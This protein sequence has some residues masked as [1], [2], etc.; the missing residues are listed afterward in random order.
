MKNSQET[1]T[2]K[3]YKFRKENVEFSKLFLEAI[4]LEK[5]G[6]SKL[7]LNNI[8]IKLKSLITLQS[9]VASDFLINEDEKDE[10]YSPIAYAI[11]QGCND[12]IKFLFS[13]GNLIRNTTEFKKL[14]KFYQFIISKVE[15]DSLKDFIE[16]KKITNS[17]DNS[18]PNFYDDSFPNYKDIL[19]NTFKLYKRISIDEKFSNIL[20]FT[21]SKLKLVDI[22]LLNI[23]QTRNGTEIQKIF[24]DKIK[25]YGCK[26]DLDS[27]LTRGGLRDKDHLLA[28]KTGLDLIKYLT[29][30]DLIEYKFK[31]TN[32]LNELV[33]IYVD[34]KIGKY[35]FYAKFDPKAFMNNALDY[36]QHLSSKNINLSLGNTFFLYLLELDI[37]YDSAILALQNESHLIKSISSSNT[38]LL[39]AVLNKYNLVKRNNDTKKAEF[40]KKIANFILDHIEDIGLEH[41]D[42][43]GRN[44]LHLAAN[45]NDMELYQKIKAL[46]PDLANIPDNRKYTPISY[47]G[48]MAIVKKIITKDNDIEKPSISD[49]IKELSRLLNIPYTLRTPA[50]HEQ[51]KG[52]IEKIKAILDDEEFDYT[53]ID[54]NEH[55]IIHNN[56]FY[57][58]LTFN[59]LQANRILINAINQCKNNDPEVSDKLFGLKLELGR[60]SELLFTYEQSGNALTNTQK[61]YKL[62]IN[63]LF[64]N[65]SKKYISSNNS[66]I[67]FKESYIESIKG[68]F[69]N[70]FK[71]ELKNFE[72]ILGK[73]LLNTGERFNEFLNYQKTL[74]EPN[75]SYDDKHNFLKDYLALIGVTHSQRPLNASESIDSEDASDTTDSEDASEIIDSKILFEE[76]YFSCLPTDISNHILDLTLKSNNP[77]SD[78]NPNITGTILLPETKLMNDF[79]NLNNITTTIHT[80]SSRALVFKPELLNFLDLFNSDIIKQHLKDIGI[81]EEDQPI[82]VKSEINDKNKVMKKEAATNRNEKP[83][84]KIKIEKVM[85]KISSQVRKK[86]LVMKLFKLNLV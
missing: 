49:T 79:Q 19:S 54:R 58:N 68:K 63:Q 5:V 20:D 10:V 46:N 27:C 50:E 84:K 59:D 31:N 18:F 21:L 56:I 9:A 3:S 64:H 61:A 33:N 67:P 24:L 16:S 76:T 43:Q 6:N 48:D 86:C 70:I 55:T 77:N 80:F 62:K 40:F 35:K 85:K 26:F 17:N 30:A 66:L 28:K 34:I 11:K 8:L 52:S 69:L 47:F 38:T 51:L 25:K 36:V 82:Q 4:K 29:D 74:I 13:N 32:I 23:I 41:H 73:V 60:L 71:E 65:D 78:I 15:F 14:E 37:S 2:S 81:I 7:E 42:N 39:M 57:T 75:E 83:A 44:A 45:C 1:F 53:T 22:T 12:I 72:V